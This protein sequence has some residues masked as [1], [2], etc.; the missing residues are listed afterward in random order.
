MEIEK[1]HRRVEEFSECSDLSQIQHYCKDI[2]MY[3]ICVYVHASS[4][5]CCKY[6]KVY[7]LNSQIKS[8]HVQV[9]ISRAAL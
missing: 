6:C 7:L 9:N 5:Y 3:I 8:L 2:A 4:A 1:S